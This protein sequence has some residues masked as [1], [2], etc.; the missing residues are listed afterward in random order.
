MGSVCL[1]DAICVVFF[2]SKKAIEVTAG[3][4]SCCPFIEKKK[5]DLF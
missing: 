1:G 3:G 5:V 4:Q 2:I